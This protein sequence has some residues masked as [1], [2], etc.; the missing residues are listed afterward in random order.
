MA[1]AVQTLMMN[2]VLLVVQEAVALQ[3][4][5]IIPAAQVHKVLVAAVQVSEILVVVHLQEIMQV[6]AAVAQLQQVQTEVET[7]AVMVVKVKHTAFQVHQ[8]IIQA[9]VA[10][11]VAPAAR[12]AGSGCMS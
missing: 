9:A 3:A 10:A 6:L 11:Q 1:V 5:Q 4:V 8:F 12:A 2:Q 7:M